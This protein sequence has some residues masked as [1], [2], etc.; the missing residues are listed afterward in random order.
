MTDSF[1]ACNFRSIFD[2]YLIKK[3]YYIGRASDR[4]CQALVRYQGNWCD[5]KDWREDLFH[6]AY[7]PRAQDTC[8]RWWLNE[9]CRNECMD[10][11]KSVHRVSFEAILNSKMEDLYGYLNC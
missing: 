1:S 11:W 4:G 2:P 6:Y 10:G 9:L 8:I 5:G 7:D 3:K